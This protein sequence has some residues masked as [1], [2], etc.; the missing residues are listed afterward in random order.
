MLSY[1]K[2]RRIINKRYVPRTSNVF[3]WFEAPCV[4]EWRKGL[5]RALYRSYTSGKFTTKQ[6]LDK[7]TK[8]S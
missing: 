2:F 3:K 6:F 1:R 7:W 8:K 5:T 4:T